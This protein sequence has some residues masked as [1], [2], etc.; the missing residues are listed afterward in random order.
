LRAYSSN[1]FSAVSGSSVLY[2]VPSLQR[3]GS[4]IVEPGTCSVVAADQYVLLVSTTDDGAV[5][6]G[7]V[8]PRL[9]FSF[10]KE[11]S[12]V[13]AVHRPGRL[14]AQEAEHCGRHVVGRGE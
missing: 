14:D 9:G 4:D 8:I 13:L 10:F 11:C 12:E 6:Q 5:D 7:E 3:I 1:I 2:E